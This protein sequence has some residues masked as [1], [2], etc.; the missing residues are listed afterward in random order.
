MLN[1]FYCSLTQ[2]SLHSQFLIVI[3]GQSSKIPFND[4][5]WQ[6]NET[7]SYLR[8]KFLKKFWTD[9]VS[10]GGCGLFQRT[11]EN[12]VNSK[13][14]IIVAGSGEGGVPRYYYKGGINPMSQNPA[15]EKYSSIKN[16]S[17]EDFAAWRNVEQRNQRFLINIIPI[18]GNID[19][20]KAKFENIKK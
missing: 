5:D 7:L 10:E 17:P 12:D 6:N 2:F 16:V 13:C 1:Y 14:E 9:P 8:A 11:S 18:I 3:E 15:E 20:T 4:N 19:V